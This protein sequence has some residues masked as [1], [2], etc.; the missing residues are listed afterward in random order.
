MICVP[1]PSLSPAQ[2]PAFEDGKDAFH[3]VPLI[4]GEFRDAVE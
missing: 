1:L 4:P 3:H 2:E